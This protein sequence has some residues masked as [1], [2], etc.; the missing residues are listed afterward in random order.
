MDE[1]LKN[2]EWYS[3]QR[4]S[5][6]GQVWHFKGEDTFRC[7]SCNATYG[8]REE[9]T[10]EKLGR[11][12]GV[13]KNKP[14]LLKKLWDKTIFP[15]MIEAR[16]QRKRIE[17]KRKKEEQEILAE[18]KSEARK[19]ALQELKPALKERI[20]E[21][22]I[23]K[24][25]GQDKEEKKKKFAQAFSFGGGGDPN[26]PNKYVDMLGMGHS[27]IGS[28]SKINRMLG[29]ESETENLGSDKHVQ[30]MLG[31]VG[32]GQVATDDKINN[33]IGL[34]QSRGPQRGKRKQQS[35]PVADKIR[36]MLS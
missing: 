25:T 11:M 12:K 27:R 33:M 2:S 9:T 19:E 7:N 24:M 35:D 8:V 5:C 16:K 21:Q 14:G 4:C 31:G 26:K 13:E 23:K 17:R 18:V 22:E 6:G 3:G 15:D 28:D 30:D 32:S 1:N 36:R 34:R 20:K 29:K 10:V